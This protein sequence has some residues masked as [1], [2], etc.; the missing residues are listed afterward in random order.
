MSWP[1]T[2]FELEI[3]NELDRYRRA[4]ERIEANAGCLVGGAMC[5]QS[6]CPGCIARQALAEPSGCVSGDD[7]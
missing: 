4:L 3:Q 5:S 1:G 6:L 7:R 2:D